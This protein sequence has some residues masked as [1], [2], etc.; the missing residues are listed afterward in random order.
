MIRR[1]LV[2]R[3]VFGILTG[4]I[5]PFHC[6]R[7]KILEVV[8]QWYWSDRKQC[9]A[10]LSKNDFL[11]KSATEMAQLIRTKKITSYELIKLSIE[12]IQQV[13]T[14]SKFRASIVQYDRCRKR[15]FN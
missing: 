5:V 9:P 2:K 15:Q 1:K 4:L 13:I 12:R 8:L 11:M 3:I 7:N 14:S 10:I 6:I